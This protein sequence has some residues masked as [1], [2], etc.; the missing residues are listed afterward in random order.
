[1]R[2]LRY[3]S[4]PTYGLTV[5]EILSSLRNDFLDLVSLQKGHSKILETLGPI[6]AVKET[7]LDEVLVVCEGLHHILYTCHSADVSDY[8]IMISLWQY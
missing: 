6:D 8:L 3:L 7:S 2:G 4:Q 5:A 1:M